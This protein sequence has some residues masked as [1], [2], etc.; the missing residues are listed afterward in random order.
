MIAR[1]SNQSILKGINPECSLEGLMLKLK[2]Q[3][4]G[5]LMQELTHWKRPW[6]CERLKAGGE[7]DNIGWDDWVTSLTQWTWVW[8]SSRRW[9]KTG[10]PGVPQSMGCR[11]RHDWATEWQQQQQ[12]YDRE[13]LILIL[14]IISLG[15]FIEISTI[16]FHQLCSILWILPTAYIAINEHILL[17]LFS[18]PS[19]LILKMV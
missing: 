8:A 10:K 13:N 4:S 11:V 14:Y 18:L 1:I 12:N 15:S 19:L 7:G 17:S 2:L 6:H 16:W 5:L 9:W 3:Y